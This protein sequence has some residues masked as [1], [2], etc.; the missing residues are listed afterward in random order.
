MA[1]VLCG[2]YVKEPLGN[3][4][5]V[6][7]PVSVAVPAGST[8]YLAVNAPAVSAITNFSATDTKSNTWTQRVLGTAASLVNGQ[9]GILECRIATALTTSD[10]INVVANTRTPDK[11]AVIA[12]A[13]DDLPVS[14]FEAAATP[15]TGLSSSPASGSRTNT[16][17]DALIFAAHGLTGAPTVTPT[18]GY[19]AS[20]VQ[21]SSTASS[22]KSL[23][24]EWKYVT[25]SAAQTSTPTL[26]GSQTWTSHILSSKR[27]VAAPSVSR[28]LVKGGVWYP[29]T[30]VFG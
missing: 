3:V 22:P 24:V 15:T 29:A 16:Q 1:G 19:T 28:Y 27:T 7:V 2:V 11:W 5:N 12:Y 26:N 9:V 20:A 18:S 4:G 21:T 8:I 23:Y 14:A 6:T 30:A 17:A 25:A 13:F 10:T